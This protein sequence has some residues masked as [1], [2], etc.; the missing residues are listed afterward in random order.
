MKAIVNTGEHLPS[1]QRP[2]SVL[3]VGDVMKPVPCSQKGEVLIK[4]H[5]TA[6][7]RA[8][9][10]Q[11]QGKYPP[12]PG[13]TPILGLECAGEIVDQKT[14]EPTGERIMALLP[15]GGYAQYAKVLKSH[16]I[17]IPQGISMTDAA[18]IPEVWLTAY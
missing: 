12:P 10:M 18:A 14:L 4:V 16:T 11:R 1:G 15:G 8:D 9:I 5:A 7:N 6:V 2:A 3:Q 13:V 17:T